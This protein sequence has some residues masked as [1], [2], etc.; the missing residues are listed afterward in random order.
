MVQQVYAF[1]RSSFPGPG[2]D[3]EENSLV[4]ER[5]GKTC[6]HNISYNTAIVIICFASRS[7]ALIRG[8]RRDHKCAP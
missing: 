4:F 1:M 2:K 5:R 7:W 6:P 8:T 3:D